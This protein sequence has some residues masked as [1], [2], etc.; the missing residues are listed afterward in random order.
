MLDES[1]E[2]CW[3]YR[4]DSGVRLQLKALVHRTSDGIPY[5]AP[6]VQLLYK[7]KA[8]RSRDEADFRSVAPNLGHEARNWLLQSLVKTLP[9]HPWIGEL[10]P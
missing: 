7:A 10:Q 5:L 9:S 8:A 3:V 2:N 1:E 4:R 6:E